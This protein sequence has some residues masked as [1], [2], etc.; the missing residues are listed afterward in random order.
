[1]YVDFLYNLCLKYF[2]FYEED[3]HKLI[4]VFI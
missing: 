1:M 2:S 3:N 4:L